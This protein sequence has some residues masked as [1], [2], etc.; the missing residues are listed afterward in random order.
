MAPP[1]TGLCHQMR[2]YLRGCPHPFELPR[3]PIRRDQTGEARMPDTVTA[4]Q[5]QGR[6][7]DTKDEW[8]GI[9]NKEWRN[10]T[11]SPS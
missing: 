10:A 2:C 5:V 4:T 7:I 6:A 11:P 9:Q 3:T 1:S 8:L